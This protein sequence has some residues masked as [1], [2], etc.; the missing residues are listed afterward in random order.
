MDADGV[1]VVADGKVAHTIDQVGQGIE[2][3]EDSHRPREGIDG[4]ERI[5]GKEQQS[6]QSLLRP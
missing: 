3:G 4:I 2:L 5:A 1:E 6:G